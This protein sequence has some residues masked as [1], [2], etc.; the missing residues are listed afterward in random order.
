MQTNRPI[1][2]VGVIVLLAL[3]GFLIAKTR[4]ELATHRT[5][6]RPADVR[7][8]FTIEGEGKVSGTPTLAEISFG[9]LSEGTDVAKIQQENTRKVN[10][11]IDAVKALNVQEKD[12][13][14]SQYSINPKYDYKDGTSKV[15]GYQVSQ[16]ISVKVRD[17]S[18][19]GDLLT[20]VGQLGGNQVNGPTF[21]IDDP[22]SLNQEARL[23]ALQDARKKAKA[24]S[25]VL[26]V[27]IGRVVTF[28]ETSNNP[29]PMPVMYRTLEVASDTAQ[30]MPSIQTGSLDVMSHVS[31]TFE[32]L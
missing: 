11:M 18:K 25:G 9:L 17:L 6:G 24:L 28:S 21:T 5:I 22:S 13:Q 1:M 12:I 31:V 16:N 4:N 15:S 20:R 23:E 2:I 3:F 14:T 27:K 10:A 32:V 29:S 30:S 7:D 26:G 19:I 8:T